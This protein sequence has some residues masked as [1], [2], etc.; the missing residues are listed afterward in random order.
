ME[1]SRTPTRVKFSDMADWFR[2]RFFGVMFFSLGLLLAGYSAWRGGYWWW[3]LWP[4]LSLLAAGSAYL[5]LGPVVFGKTPEGSYGA[6]PDGG[7][8]FRRQE[9]GESGPGE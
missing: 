7:L 4:A 1:N 2:A 9:E 5:W 8:T 6:A 3:L